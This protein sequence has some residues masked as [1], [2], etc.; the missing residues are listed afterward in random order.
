MQCTKYN[1]QVIY[2]NTYYTYTQK[3]REKKVYITVQ[4]TVSTIKSDI[5]LDYVHPGYIMRTCECIYAVL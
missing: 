3:K 1:T 4:T 2:A 5:M